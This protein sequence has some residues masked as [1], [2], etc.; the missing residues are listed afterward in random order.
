MLIGLFKN[1]V[2]S[3]NYLYLR[4]TSEVALK[5]EVEKRFVTGSEHTK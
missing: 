4:N 1:Q 2:R 3:H 5:T